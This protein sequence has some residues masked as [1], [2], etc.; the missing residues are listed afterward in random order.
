VPRLVVNGIVV[1]EEESRMWKDY[2]F[3]YFFS[4]Q[5][6][7]ILFFFYHMISSMIYVG[8]R[9]NDIAGKRPQLALLANAG[10]QHTLKK[11]SHFEIFFYSKCVKFGTKSM[12]F[13][14]KNQS[15]L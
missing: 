6:P 12:H 9:G 14:K 15:A 11:K 1:L 3:I 10:W 7:V 4:T 2:R 8:Y 13:E 5:A